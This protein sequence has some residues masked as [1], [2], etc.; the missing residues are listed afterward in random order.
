MASLDV[1]C[2]FLGS[3]VTHGHLSLRG[4]CFLQEINS[5]WQRAATGLLVAI[6][7]HLPDLVSFIIE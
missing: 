7:S 5:D 2:Y 6:G 3:T 4:N 1:S